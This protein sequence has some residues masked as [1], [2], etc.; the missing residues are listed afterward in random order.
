MGDS[1][2]QR[3]P[4]NVFDKKTFNFS[5][6]AEHYCFTYYKLKKILAQN[7]CNTELV[8][9]GVSAHNFS[10]VY[11]K[12]FDLE[13]SEGLSSLKNFLYYLNLVDNEAF[14]LYDMLSKKEFYQGI[15]KGP[16]RNRV[17]KSS[18][19]YPKREDIEK[20]ID[21]HFSKD[22]LCIKIDTQVYFLRKI[23][24][25]CN[26]N[27]VDIVFI[28]TPVHHYY[29]ERIPNDNMEIF[30]QITRKF[31]VQQIDYL[32]SE[33]PD[34]LMSDGNHLNLKGAKY[35]GDLIAKTIAKRN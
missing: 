13:K 12:L 26:E 25:L 19:K 23:V 22:T 15:L 1:Q 34:S 5:N 14:S 4:N 30:R 7:K 6:K 16:L 28:S 33:T 20:V 8:L 11:H 9:L 32:T 24:E 31:D 3:L 35:Y 21:M 17:I 27:K 10:A 2:M 18:N 29:K